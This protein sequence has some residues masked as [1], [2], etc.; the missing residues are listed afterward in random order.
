MKKEHKRV[1]DSSKSY[2]LERIT[3]PHFSIVSQIHDF[4]NSDFSV[5]AIRYDLLGCIYSACARLFIK[6][7]LKC[8]KITL[9]FSVVF[10]NVTKMLF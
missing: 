5:K 9:S 7:F 8:W 4:V 10:S 3:A 1:N 6:T 2:A